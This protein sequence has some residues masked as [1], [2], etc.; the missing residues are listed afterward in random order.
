MLNLHK[1]NVRTYVNV[2]IAL[3]L[4]FRIKLTICLL[5][6]QDCCFEATIY[7][8]KQ[9]RLSH[10][11]CAPEKVN[12]WG[13]N[14]KK[15]LSELKVFIWYSL[16][17]QWLTVSWA[18]DTVIHWMFRSSQVFAVNRNPEEVGMDQSCR[19]IRL[20]VH[21]QRKKERNTSKAI[22]HF[23]AAKHFLFNN[24]GNISNHPLFEVWIY[25]Y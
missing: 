16:A 8:G 1:L 18:A 23:L 19:S 20:I 11:E 4:Y 17:S 13:L 2:W 12:R 10:C 15:H 21:R 7:Y 14:D 9:I 6:F 22:S 5:Y 24:R 25:N 3:I